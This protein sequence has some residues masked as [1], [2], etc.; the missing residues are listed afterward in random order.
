[1]H[2]TLR[3]AV[4][5]AIVMPALIFSQDNAP[6][7]TDKAQLQAKLT[8]TDITAKLEA[9]AGVENYLLSLPSLDKPQQDI[10]LPLIIGL[11]QDQDGTVSSQ[12]T[13]LLKKLG[14]KFG[15]PV[16]DTLLAALQSPHAMTR[17]LAAEALG[18][19]GDKRA[20]TPLLKLMLEDKDVYARGSAA[21]ALGNLRA[22]ETVEP[23]IALLKDQSVYRFARICAAEALGKLGDKRAIE[24]L[25]KALSDKEDYVRYAAA[26]AL[27]EFPEQAV[28]EPLIDIVKLEQNGHIRTIVVQSLVKI[29]DKNPKLQFKRKDWSLLT[30]MVPERQALQE[31]KPSIP[32]LKLQIVVPWLAYLHKAVE[33]KIWL[34]NHGNSTLSGLRLINVLTRNLDYIRSRPAGQWNPVSRIITWNLPTLAPQE[35]LEISVEARI[36]L[37][38]RYANIAQVTWNNQTI[39]ASQDIQ[40]GCMPAMHLSTYDTEDPVEIGQRTIYVVEVRNE[41]V[42][43]CTNLRLI[44]IIPEQMKFVSACVP[45]DERIKY[46]LVDR[47]VRFDTVPLLPIG[48]KITYRITC[49]A[50]KEGSAKN[51]AI[52]HWD[53]FSRDITD[54]EG[55][56]VY[57]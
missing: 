9:L 56:S 46:T 43:E 40:S 35:N 24:P 4:L 27:G 29:G 53:Q 1:M 36:A 15:V 12:A 50:I 25:I 2:T 33:Y 17:Y 31:A 16:V 21:S 57:K 6:V 41:S 48:E 44:N 18:E 45:C 5:L 38:G 14:K 30:D 37:A 20:T 10:W 28:V 13:E 8:D 42:S 3:I 19:I 22:V 54:D 55:T 34:T 23:L 32:D 49:V 52:L 47:Q 7:T 51:I 11:L 39:R 26:H